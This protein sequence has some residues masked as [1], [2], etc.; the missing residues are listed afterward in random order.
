MDI[1]K[2]A[3]GLQALWP[4]VN[5]TFTPDLDRYP[6][7]THQGQCTPAKLSSISYVQQNLGLRLLDYPCHVT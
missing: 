3:D 5:T 4:D 6:K 7:S 1:L 2:V